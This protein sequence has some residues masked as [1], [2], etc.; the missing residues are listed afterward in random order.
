MLS[1]S[2]GNLIILAIATVM[3]TNST[4]KDEIC[5]RLRQ[6][7]S[8]HLNILAVGKTDKRLLLITKDFYVYDTPLKSL[9]S[10]IDK[11]YLKTQ[12]IPLQDKYPQLFFNVYFITIKDVISL[13]WIMNDPDSDW[14]C[15]APRYETGLI[16]VNYDIDNSEPRP[17][18]QNRD[19]DDNP[20][21]L[22]STNRPCQY[23]S[24]RFN[25]GLLMNRWHCVGGDSLRTTRG[26]GPIYTTDSILCSDSRDSG[27]IT[28]QRLVKD[29]QGNV[30]I[31]CHRGNPLNWPIVKGFVTDDKFYLFGRTN[32][33]IFSEQVYH[34]HGAEYPVQKR[35]YDSFFNCAGFI[36]P[37]FLS[38]SYFYWIM[39]AII[40][41]LLILMIILWC[42][43]VSRR[44]HRRPATVSLIH[45]K[46][47]R[48]GLNSELN[49]AKMSTNM[50]TTRSKSMTQQTIQSIS[51]ASSRPNRP[52]TLSGGSAHVTARTGL[53]QNAST[54]M[55]GT[56]ASKPNQLKRL[57]IIPS[58]RHG[59][60]TTA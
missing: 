24:L 49:V 2:V 7:D 5:E 52:S 39:G 37:S 43:L 17:G 54:E 42:I 1:S 33:Y 10:D 60:S 26:I 13:A 35:S 6:N 12:P 51:M 48:S 41:L 23:Y 40:L 38:K 32:I 44:R 47:T 14:I 58:S 53:D 21:V 55:L 31:E 16:G 22:L 56:S 20:L 29:E 18:F 45:A 57:T 28:A 36:P 19:R 34:N 8:A 27:N 50:A 15:L 3:A 9:D 11:L 25:H 30:I 46:T 4:K 59:G